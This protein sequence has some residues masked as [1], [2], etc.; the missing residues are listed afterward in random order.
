MTILLKENCIVTE[1]SPKHLV[2]I[3]IY[4]YYFINN[5]YTYIKATN[6]DY[7]RLEIQQLKNFKNSKLYENLFIKSKYIS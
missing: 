2:I 1:D 4:Y 6:V 3:Y 5:I 7:H